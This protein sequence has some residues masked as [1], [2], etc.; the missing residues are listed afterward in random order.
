MDVRL[1]KTIPYIA[2]Y[3]KMWYGRAMVKGIKNALVWPLWQALTARFAAVKSGTGA[4]V[5]LGMPRSGTSIAARLVAAGGVY[6]G[7]QSQMR[8]AD[9]R[10]EDGFLELREMNKLDDRLVAE[11]GFASH[12]CAEPNLGLRA[13]S[14]QR[15][16]RLKTRYRMQRLLA[17]LAQKT[18]WGFKET[19]FTFYWWRTYVPKARIVAIYRDPRACAD[20]I[21]RTFGRFTYGQALDW[22]TRGNTELLYHL[23]RHDSVLVKMEDLLDPSRQDAALKK[24]AAFCGGSAEE[25]KQSLPQRVRSSGRDTLQHMPALPMQTQAVLEALE[26]LAQER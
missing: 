18:P 16:S 2:K 10:N 4:I 21:H 15:M 11:S 19:P 9:P 3:H 20:S 5:V 24:I 8:P 25:L 22:W 14:H 6:F 12:L 7:A 23:S 1:Q 26:K 13:V 17:S